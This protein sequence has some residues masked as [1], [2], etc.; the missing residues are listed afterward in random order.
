MLMEYLDIRPL[1]P[2]DRVARSGPAPGIRICDCDIAADGPFEPGRMGEG[3]YEAVFCRSGRLTLTLTAGRGVTLGPGEML[4]VTSAARL[5]A[6]EFS[7]GR[8]SGFSARIETGRAKEIFAHACAVLS[9][10]PLDLQ[11][12]RRILESHGGVMRLREEDWNAGVFAALRQLTPDRQGGYLVYKLIELLYLL[13]SRGA[14]AELP[15]GCYYDPYQVEAVRKV[16]AYMTA[17]SEERLTI[18]ELTR[19]FQ[20]SPTFLKACFRQLYGESVHAYLQRYRLQ[21]AAHLLATTRDSVLTVASKVG[22]AG[23]SR[24]GAAFKELYHMTPAQYRRMYGG[25]KALPEELPAAD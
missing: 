25:R 7:F 22:Y 15:P 9:D 6:A 19:R 3:Q 11:K 2:G 4:L 10:A 23:T 16:Q 24:F 5:K 13:C 12:L 14:Q 21:R 1:Q 18:S 20:L 8:F 17:H